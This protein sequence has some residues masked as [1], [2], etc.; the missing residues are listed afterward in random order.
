MKTK[1]HGRGT[2]PHHLPY[3][4]LPIIAWSQANVRSVAD[5]YAG[6]FSTLHQYSKGSCPLFNEKR[7]FV[8]TKGELRSDGYVYGVKEADGKY[9]YELRYNP[10]PDV[11]R[12]VE[13]MDRNYILQLKR[14][15]KL[16]EKEPIGDQE[17]KAAEDTP[18]EKD[19]WGRRH[20]FH[21]EIFATFAA[22]REEV[23]QFGKELSEKERQEKLEKERLESERQERERQ[24]REAHEKKL[25]GFR[26]KGLLQLAKDKNIDGI[27]YLLSL[28]DYDL[29]VNAV[30]D[31]DRTALHHLAMLGNLDLVK[32]LLTKNPDVLLIDACDKTP[33]DYAK[34]GNH[35][36]IAG[37]LKRAETA[38]REKQISPAAPLREPDPKPSAGGSQRPVLDSA[39]VARISLKISWAELQVEEELGRGGFGV[40]YKGQWQFQHVAIK[41]LH[42]TQ[43]TGNGQ[44]EFMREAAVMVQLRHDNIIG[45]KGIVLEP[46]HYSLV[47]ELMPNLS[48]Y[49]VL[50]S[51]KL[52]WHVKYNI[53]LDVGAG[54]SYLHA[55]A[56]LHR[57]LKS[58]N[59]LLD[60]NF[61]AKLT[62]FGL[63]KLR[64]ET[65]A[66]TKA[67]QTVGTLR[68]MAPE[69]LK[70]KP[71]YS[72][73]S[74]VYSYG[75]ILW[76]LAAEKIPYEE[77]AVDLIKDC[78][79]DGDVEELPADSPPPYGEIVKRCWQAK[80]DR[81]KAAD[82]L[83]S[84]QGLRHLG[85][86]AKP[87]AGAG[88]APAWVEELLDAVRAGPIHSAECS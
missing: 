56:I 84:L 88:E 77:T 51:T 27:R 29:R 15:G 87:G 16:L 7:D 8:W 22:A 48:L 23:K 46:T 61:R 34:E 62:D 36:E 43:M 1:N 9:H 86:F 20:Q 74:D 65:S 40:V 39:G 78:I 64:I 41:Q 33:L 35:A 81:P 13:E 53:A 70:R 2:L 82:V 66:T 75:L 3:D 68:W 14:E 47:M 38:A 44:T 76:E 30:D 54:L 55:Q 71:E 60:G 31:G 21:D 18:A 12:W 80:D 72:E 79:K 58:M 24:A 32:I 5:Y 17:I 10:A 83:R 45:L 49:N 42:L 69:L 59:V 6:R 52:P 63:A 25:K 85:I 26:E 73:A 19:G 50:Q 57:D 11:I 4:K 37:C 28:S 67:E